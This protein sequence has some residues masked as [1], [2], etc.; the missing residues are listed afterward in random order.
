MVRSILKWLYHFNDKTIHRLMEYWPVSGKVNIKIQHNAIHFYSEADDALVSKLYYGKGWEE[1]ELQIFV[2]LAKQANTIFDVGGNIGLYSLVAAKANPGS[3][4]YCF[5]PNPVNAKRIRKN[6]LNNRL[7]NIQLVEKAVA[8][9]AGKVSFFL[10]DKDLIS[11]VSSIYR[12]HTTSFSDFNI[13]EIEV[14]TVSIDNF[15]KDISRPPQLIK[16]DVELAEYE[17]L[18]GMKSLLKNC[19]PVIICEVFNDV[20]KLKLNPALSK[21]LEE[22][23]TKLIEDILKA[24]NYHAYLIA[25]SGLLRVDNL[26]SNPDSAMYLFTRTKTKYSFYP[27][28]EIENFVFEVTSEMKNGN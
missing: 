19:S 22:G 7:T 2:A 9:G 20:V 5:E 25:K 6:I 1:L 17:A 21:E 18:L 15:I 3:A 16:I 8:E 12:S 23:H 24:Y 28:N 10:P 26:R 11:D 14:E 27:R 4:V 13:N